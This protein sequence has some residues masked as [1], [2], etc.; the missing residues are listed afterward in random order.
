[1]GQ[2]AQLITVND[3]SML[4]H[5]LPFPQ[6]R[7]EGMPAALAVTDISSLAASRWPVAGSTAQHSAALPL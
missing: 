6:Q 2:A 1:M 3:S 4:W 7:P 5:E